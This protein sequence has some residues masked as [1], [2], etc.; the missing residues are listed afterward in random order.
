MKVKLDNV[1]YTIEM[2]DKTNKD[3]GDNTRGIVYYEDLKI[4]L[5]K[6]LPDDLIIQTLYHEISHAMCAQTSF[7]DM[8]ADKLG[9]NG[10]EIFIDNMGKL[11]Y[12]IIHNNDMK[13]LERK[14]LKKNVTKVNKDNESNSD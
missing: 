3:L 12:D 13:T 9:D 6:N 11:L 10:Y 4:L 8:L 14:A 5:D 2:T 1:N 7:N